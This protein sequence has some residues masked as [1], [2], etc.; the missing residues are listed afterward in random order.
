[1]VR[2]PPDIIAVPLFVYS[3]LK[4]GVNCLT[5]AFLRLPDCYLPAVYLGCIGQRIGRIGPLSIRQLPQ[6]L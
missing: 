3:L 6:M 2:K 5:A 4:S 1:M